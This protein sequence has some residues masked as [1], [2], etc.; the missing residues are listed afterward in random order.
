MIS[1]CTELFIGHFFTLDL[2]T[3]KYRIIHWHGIISGLVQ[4]LHT[5]PEQG[6]VHVLKVRIGACYE[7]L[8]SFPRVDLGYLPCTWENR[9]LGLEV[10]W[11]GPFRL[12]GLFRRRGLWFEAMHFFFSLYSLQ[13]YCLDIICGGLFFHLETFYRFLFMHKI[14][15]RVVCVNGEQPSW[16]TH[17]SQAHV[18]RHKNKP[19]LNEGITRSSHYP[20]EADMHVRLRVAFSFPYALDTIFV[21][22]IHVVIP[23]WIGAEFPGAVL[24]WLAVSN[25][26]GVILYVLSNFTNCRLKQTC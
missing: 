18:H 26:E 6:C 15:T 3:C 10:E 7:K 19:F 5:H 25:T 11:S 14:S 12:T 17:T 21:T 1:C 24:L 13:I 20:I 9:T 8:N 16:W 22:S 2:L 23:L 4:L